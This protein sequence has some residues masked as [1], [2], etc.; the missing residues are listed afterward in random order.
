M[1]PLRLI[2]A[3]DTFRALSSCIEMLDGKLAIFITEPEFNGL[4]PEVNGL[5]DQVPS[6]VGL[7]VESSGSTGT[8]KRIQLSVEALKASAD[9]SARR[10]GGQGQWLLALPT[11]FIAGVNVLVRSVIADTQPVIMNTQLPFTADAFFRAASLMTEP[12]RFTSLVPAQLARLLEAVKTDE[13][14][15]AL[16]RRFDAILL[17]GQM[18][19]QRVVDQLR[20][21]GVR[22]VISY[23]MTETAGGCVY[24]SLPLD[25]V[26]VNIRD[27]KIAISGPVLANGL[28][29]EFVTNDL[30]EFSEG[31]LT[32]L[33]RADRVVISGGHKVSLEAVEQRAAL[34]AG[35]MEVAA[36]AMP[37]SW[38][39]SV[40][41]VYAGSPEVDFSSLEQLSVA[42]KPHRVILV[43]MLPRLQ[44]GKADLVAIQALLNQ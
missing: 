8:P 4:M 43:P 14:S 11:K 35:V 39:E 41:L 23:G 24:D 17:G 30:G 28:G 6:D 38:G 19:D 2:P 20:E 7:I 9:S 13:Y 26:G 37:S 33:G 21:L 12:K 1:K 34:I 36:A 18:P 15:L 29:A 27:G 3:N 5:P 22:I 10:L 44:S 16:L 31:K 25:G 40:G 42:A 32:V